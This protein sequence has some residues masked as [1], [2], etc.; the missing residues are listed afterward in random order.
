MAGPCWKT[1]LQL[2]RSILAPAE[3]Q[4]DLFQRSTPRDPSSPVPGGGKWVASETVLVG[5]TSVEVHFIRHPRARVFRLT[6][7]RDGSGRV[8]LP[9]YGSMPGARNFLLQHVQWLAERA[10]IQRA[11]TGPT[12]PSKGPVQIRFRGEFEAVSVSE[13]G[14]TLCIGTHPMPMPR[15]KERD[16]PARARAALQRLAQRELPQRVQELS[17]THGIPVSTIS[18]RAQRTRWGSCSPRGEI[19]LNWRLVQVPEWV[20]DYVILHELAHRRHLNHS[21]RFWQ[22]VE[23]LCPGYEAAEAWLRETGRHVL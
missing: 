7:C 9:R 14:K 16:L 11:N 20:R 22:E 13:D 3:V 2:I 18:V 19:S 4:L 10:R 23:R 17:A 5:A 12:D 1:P 6:L 8:T 21:P 15:L